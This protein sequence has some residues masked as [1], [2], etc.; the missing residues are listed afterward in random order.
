MIEN[1]IP[2]VFIS[3]SWESKEHSD[4][5][6][7][8]ADKLLADGIESIIDSYDVSPGDRLPKFMESSIRDSD[9]VII[10]CTEEYKRKANNREKGVGYES[11]IIS[12]ELYNNHNDRKFI[13]VIRQGDFNSALLT[14][15]DGKL[16]IDLRGN[17]F[18]ED[19][20]KELI[21]S[22][23][24]VKKKPKV[25]IRPYYVDEYEPITIEGDDIKIVGIITNEV[26]LPKNDGTRGSA[27]YRIHFRLSSKYWVEKLEGIYLD[28][29]MEYSV[30]DGTKVFNF[31]P[32]DI[33][34]YIPISGTAFVEDYYYEGEDWIRW[35]SPEGVEY[36]K[37][38]YWS[39]MKFFRNSSIW[40]DKYFPS[41]LAYQA[42]LLGREK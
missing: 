10:I 27:L 35:E 9:Y 36:V 38:R 33:P 29:S 14:Y 37:I 21:A 7:S 23:F 11:H 25:G 15:L 40:I 24:K 39:L 6:K 42:E 41:R 3:Y 30:E 34:E 8:L 22:I 4:W 2:K 1:N 13:P 17:P 18:N 28:E 20:Y 32:D 26:T 5:V 19:S 31:T 16:A 12:A